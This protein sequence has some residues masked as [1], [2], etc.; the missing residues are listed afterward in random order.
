MEIKEEQKEFP[1][2]AVVKIM[3]ANRNVSEVFDFFADMK[4]MEIGGAIKSIEQNDDGWWTFDHIVVGKSKMKL[5]LHQEFGILDHTFIGGGLE[6]HVY[7]RVIPNQSGST[8][9]WTFIRPDG[10]TEEQFE[11]QLKGFD[12]EID[13]W[14]KALES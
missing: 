5:T 13:G 9:T 10:M 12:N 8:A 2:K 7:V 14:K 11:E 1:R 3:N 4:N 6:W